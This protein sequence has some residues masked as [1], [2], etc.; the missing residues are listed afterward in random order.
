MGMTKPSNQRLTTCRGAAE[1][2]DTKEPTWR[3]WVAERRVTSVKL[4]RSVRI[5]L[6]EVERFIAEGTIPADRR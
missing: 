5:P 6:S 2:T 1:M 4:G 3:K